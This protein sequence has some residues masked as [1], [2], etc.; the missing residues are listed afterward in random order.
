MTVFALAKH[1]R[2]DDPLLGPVGT[3]A[4]GGFNYAGNGLNR[5]KA[6]PPPA[7]TLSAIKLLLTVIPV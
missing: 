5:N 4:K 6:S 2:M 1:H 7:E 3:L